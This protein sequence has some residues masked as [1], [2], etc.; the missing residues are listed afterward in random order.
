MKTL[1]L[2]SYA[3]FNL[4]LEVLNRR[5]DGF[6]NIRTVF[7]RVSLCDKILIRSRP[8]GKIRII[9]TS[10]EIPK[11]KTN[12]A[13]KSAAILKRAFNIRQGA[14]IKIIKHIPVSAGLGGGS[15]NAAAVLSGLNKIWDL[16]LSNK[17]LLYFARQIGSD[18]PFFICN[19]PFAYAFSRGDRL[20]PL[21]NIKVKRLW[22]ILVLPRLKVSTPF[23]YK[24]W[25]MLRN[26]KL[27]RLKGGGKIVKN[28][29]SLTGLTPLSKHGKIP[30]NTGCKLGLKKPKHGV[31]ILTLALEKN[32]LSLLNSALFNSLYEVTS[33]LYPEIGCIKTKL[34]MLGA[35]AVLMSGSGPAVFG[36]VSSGK[37][38]RD[39]FRQ[40]SREN[41]S[42][43]IFLVNSV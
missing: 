29:L 15:S 21:D 18:V 43:R 34:E 10:K 23:I 9:S 20:K 4:Y 5:K 3:K 6:H 37:E 32:D 30:L 27:T 33:G 19:K 17:R 24:K 28:Q 8:D 2:N 41:H 12:L 40:V 35:K 36:I 7:E 13:F 31:K 25:D 16:N 14:D 42:W 11:D 1:K 39:L 22:H 38:A 26:F